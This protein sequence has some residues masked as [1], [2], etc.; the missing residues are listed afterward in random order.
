MNRIER[1]SLEDLR[2]RVGARSED[3]GVRFP[4]ERCR[5][6][7][8]LAGEFKRDAARLLAAVF[9]VNDDVAH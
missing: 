1:I 3:D 6:F 5:K 8:R 9:D 2:D 7:L 4:A